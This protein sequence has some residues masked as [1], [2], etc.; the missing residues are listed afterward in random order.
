MKRDELIELYEVASILGYCIMPLIPFT[1]ANLLL[2]LKHLGGVLFMV[3]IVV[4]CSF[5]ALRFVRTVP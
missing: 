2:D 5:L 4:C 3:G 1:I